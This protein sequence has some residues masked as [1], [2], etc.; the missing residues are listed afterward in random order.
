MKSEGKTKELWCL[1]KTSKWTKVSHL[2]NAIKLGVARKSTKV[3]EKKIR[4]QKNET[5]CY[6]DGLCTLLK[7]D[8]LEQKD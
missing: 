2:R 4:L 6:R 8:T 3:W 1:W 7:G 5:M